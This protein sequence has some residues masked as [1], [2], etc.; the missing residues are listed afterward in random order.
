MKKIISILLTFAI[1]AS[2]LPVM[3]VSAASEYDVKIVF[4]GTAGGGNPTRPCDLDGTAA[5]YTVVASET[6]TAKGDNRQTTIGNTGTTVQQIDVGTGDAWLDRTENPYDS[7]FTFTVPISK[8][9][10]YSIKL[11][12]AKWHPGAEFYIYVN[13]EY[14]GFYNFTDST[15]TN[16]KPV[17]NIEKTM[18]TLYLEAGTAKIAFVLARKTQYYQW[19]NRALPISLSLDYVG[20]TE[21]SYSQI[22]HTLPKELVVGDTVSFAAYAVMSDGS[23]FRA[24]GYEM[25]SDGMPSASVNNWMSAA[26]SSGDAVAVEKTSDDLSY[27]GVYEGTITASKEGKAEI[28]LTAM[29]NG[30]PKTIVH[31]INVVDPNS[32][33]SGVNVFYNPYEVG[34]GFYLGDFTYEQSNGFYRSHSRTSGWDPV[35]GDF[36]TLNGYMVTSHKA[37]YWYALGINVPVSGYYDVELTYAQRTYASKAVDVYLLDSEEAKNIE[38]NLTA[39]NLLETVSCLDADGKNYEKTGTIEKENVNFAEAG[40]YVLVV[41]SK[42]AGYSAI[43]SLKLYGGEAFAVMKGDIAI[44]AG[45]MLKATGVLSDKAKTAV[46]FDDD[47]VSF[48]SGN[49]D[50]VTITADGKIEII[51]EGDVTIEA[52]VT[53]GERKYNFEK[54]FSFVEQVPMELAGT[55]VTYNFTKISSKWNAPLYTAEPK[56][57]EDIRGIT[58][59]Y[60]GEDGEVGNWQWESSDASTVNKANSAVAFLYA[61]SSNTGRLRLSHAPGEYVAIKI[62]VDVPGRYLVSL[63]KSDYYRAAG[64]ADIYIVPYDVDGYITDEFKYNTFVGTVDCFDSEALALTPKYV[65]LGFVQFENP[66]EYVFAIHKTRGGADEYINLRS[67]VLEGEQKLK[68]TEFSYP[69]DVIRVGETMKA[70]LKAYLLDGTEIDESGLTIRYSSS[71][72][73]SVMVERDGTV[74]AISEGDATI[75]VSVKYENTTQTAEFKLSSIDT[76][77]VSKVY[78]DA[79]ESIYVTDRKPLTFKMKMNSGNEKI[80][81]SSKVEYEIINQSSENIAVID[82]K[83]YLSAV[84][85]GT[86]QVK[87]KTVFDGESYETEAITIAFVLDDK[88]TERTIFTK[89][90]CD[91]IQENAARYS[92]AK[93]EVKEA[94]ELADQYLDNY[95]QIYELTIGE[96]VPRSRQVGGTGDPYH[97]ICRYCGV[98]TAVKYG[99][100]GVGVWSYDMLTRPWKIQCPDCKRYFPSNDFEGFYELGLD[101]NGL[102][103]YEQAKSRNAE[104][105]ANGEKGFLVN[106]LYPEVANQ[107]RIENGGVE[108]VNVT[109]NAGAG[110]RPG[111]TAEGWGVDDGWGYR[112]TDPEGNPY[113]YSN[114]VVEVH[115]HIAFYNF[116]AWQQERNI[117]KTLKKA[118]VYTGEVKYGRAGAIILDRIADVWPAM[119]TAPFTGTG[120]FFVTDGGA[121]TGKIQGR[122]NDCDF[123]V[124]FTEAA[125]AFFPM[126]NDPQ[127]ISFLSG[128]AK[129]LNLENKKESGY[130]IWK[131]WEDGIL[132]TTYEGILNTQIYGNFGQLQLALTNAAVALDHQPLTNEMLDFVYKSGAITSDKKLTGGNVSAQ[133]VDIIDRDG[134]NNEAAPNYNYVPAQKLLYVADVLGRY[135]KDPKY[136]LLQNTKFVQMY[137]AFPQVVI[138]STEAAQTGDSGTTGGGGFIAL[139]DEYILAYKLL[140]DT[141]IGSRLANHIYLLNGEKTEGLRYDITTKKPE[142]LEGEI[143]KL[144]DNEIGWQSEIMTGYGFAMLRSGAKYDTVPSQNVNNKRGV[145]LT[146]GITNVSHAHRDALNLGIIAYDLNMTPDLGYPSNTGTQPQRLQW[147]KTTLSHNTVVV[148]EKEQEGRT[149]SYPIH[150]DDAGK[151]KLVD[152]EASEQYKNTD[153]YRRTLVTVEVNDNDSYIV[154]FFR[155]KGGD[156]HLFSFHVA[157]DTISETSL[158][159]GE[160]ETGSYADSEWPYGADPNSPEAWTYETHYPRGYTWL[161]KT[162]RTSGPVG[163]YDI[164][165]EIK[166]YLKKLKDGKGLHLRLTMLNDFE[167]DEVAVANGYPPTRSAN[168]AFLKNGIKYLLARRKGSNLDS[169][170]TTVYEPYKTNRYLTD[171]DS[172]SIAPLEGTPKK[173][174]NAKAIKIE[175]KSG[176]VDYIIYSTN[177]EVT[178]QVQDGDVTLDFRGFIGVYSIQNGENVYTYL[179]DGDIL[180]AHKSEKNITGTV[181]DYSKGLTLENYIIVDPD[182][183]ASPE[184][185]V[186]KMIVV[187]NDGVQNG[188]YRILGAKTS[189]DENIKL[190]LGTVSLVRKYKDADDFEKGYIYNIYPGQRFELAGSYV[191]DE[192]PVFDDIKSVLSTSAGSTIN[193]DLNA[194]SPIEGKTVSYKAL[195]IPRGAVLNGNTGTVIWKPDASQVGDNHFTITAYDS[196]G[197]ENTIHFN[198]TVYGSTGGTGTSGGSAGGG[199]GGGAAPAPSTPSDDKTDDKTDAP[200]KD[201]G[202]T[203]KVR[204]V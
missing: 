88:K 96:G 91:N 97:S 118:Y 77:G 15:T 140:K 126:R 160:V 104:L 39:S 106:L 30:S 24:N 41:S 101:E 170:F 192:A 38:A 73:D 35:L 76:S 115:N 14:A 47:S 195:I 185:F 23:Y 86:V 173:S 163:K 103:D 67:L 102:F 29:I 189:K 166:D 142:A 151:V 31:T 105:V 111:E 186:G 44:G 19:G 5:G 85:E 153:I 48:K 154:D 95:E 37:G 61:S 59:D 9:G 110:L 129:E 45:N 7:M 12:G 1:I 172:V 130:E 84:G 184:A 200:S 174:D 94:K 204:F 8:S 159:L 64:V 157:G 175:H 197:R 191:C 201:D 4:G 87:A 193:I 40:E 187:E 156:D 132:K 123:A 134:M 51:G 137:R 136:D 148:D 144:L 62:K 116:R 81:D 71:N 21:V 3:S 27:D 74:R 177:N 99:G 119:D 194:E 42:E 57:L 16:K 33:R 98:D 139:L 63:E 26:V 93:D 117:L 178:Y 80:I 176:R 55:D 109:I 165:F 10:S 112:P 83:G 128:K 183:N 66:G 28:T 164:D 141:E 70:E 158:K 113:T 60:T 92:W 121:G 49:P 22:E 190:E 152:V 149:G 46:N 199:G 135:T 138:N 171:S 198:V 122:I 69:S 167:L 146:F 100:G 90:I 54:E 72:P 65:S 124:E 127:V 181:V 25:A 6:T 58:Y 131:N 202:E 188:A 43:G 11:L 82:D 114:G 89:E 169:L 107:V 125:D 52:E 120:K 145:Y 53:Y 50:V 196:D 133:L 20:E 79:P 147:I 18:N 150:F 17:A 108:G 56:R 143:E 78:L 13:G 34:Y 182:S 203:E 36:R 162:Q 155:A 168:E 2:M 75:T 179:S 32:N 68:F 180:G 161:D